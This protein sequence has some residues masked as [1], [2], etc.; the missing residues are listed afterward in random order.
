MAARR[1][2][3]SS[4]SPLTNSKNAASAAVIMSSSL[5]SASAKVRD[6][7]ELKQRH[8]GDLFDV[9]AGVI[10][11]A[12]AAG[13]LPS[14]A[15]PSE[16]ESATAE[17][18]F[19]AATGPVISNGLLPPPQQHHDG[20]GDGKGAE[21]ATTGKKNNCLACACKSNCGMREG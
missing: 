14:H 7:L 16:S 19:S 18:S 3:H 12:P 13:G 11:A 4:K 8:M 21:H 9:G 6:E 20:G 15:H 1:Q 17:T 10:E 2:N 5:A